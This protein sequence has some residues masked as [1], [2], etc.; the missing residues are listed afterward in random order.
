MPGRVSTPA[1]RRLSDSAPSVRLDI[2]GTQVHS[3]LS[4]IDV[5][6]TVYFGDDSPGFLGD[7]C[8]SRVRRLSSDQQLD[9]RFVDE[10]G[11]EVRL[12]V[13]RG[14]L[15]LTVDGSAASEPVRQVSYNTAT[16]LLEVE[17]EEVGSCVVPVEAR[18][19]MV[20]SLTHI[21]AAAR[22][23]VNF[24]SA[25]APSRASSI[26]SYAAVDETMTSPSVAAPT[27]PPTALARQGPEGGGGAQCEGTPAVLVLDGASPECP[28][29]RPCRRSV[30]F[31]E[32]P[33]PPLEVA[34][35]DEDGDAVR[36]GVL[37]GGGL[38]LTVNGET[39]V[40]EVERIELDRSSGRV[41]VCGA[42]TG[43]CTIPAAMRAQV[44]AR[45]AAVA[46]AAS[47]PLSHTDS[48]SPSSTPVA[49]PS[50]PPSLR[51]RMRSPSATTATTVATAPTAAPKAEFDCHA[52]A[53]GE[54][55]QSPSAD[56][57]PRLRTPD[58][59][60]QLLQPPS[61]LRAL[62]PQSPAAP[63]SAVAGPASSPL[64][65]RNMS[66]TVP[67]T[68]VSSVSDDCLSIGSSRQRLSPVGTDPADRQ[69]QPIS[70]LTVSDS[71]DSV[72]SGPGG[73]RGRQSAPPQHPARS[74]AEACIA[75]AWWADWLVSERRQ[76]ALA[77]ARRGAV[78]GA[79]QSPADA[80]SPPP[81]LRPA[82][83]PGSPPRRYHPPAGGHWQPQQQ[84]QRRGLDNVQPLPVW[85]T[86]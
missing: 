64:V 39:G 14:A 60:S 57:V 21:C 74:A 25:A 86:A 41:T 76:A 12:R 13:S 5:L 15:L 72:P 46:D 55:L 47:V 30:S 33:R 77:G 10:D 79:L 70:P 68:Q 32:S 4:D 24:L 58:S 11:D 23:P 36:L 78:R 52:E 48:G 49:A 54:E 53:A 37:E 61:G 71:A 19:T 43:T 7:T 26:V 9:F 6:Q 38:R 42:V 34:F 59:Q 18:A 35:V 62:E 82:P 50:P 28:E 63:L 81:Q 51:R 2:S 44:A 75:P 3:P 27:P 20:R 65:P 22:V 67:V 56:T 80:G 69:H 85:A 66:Y 83:A 31:A 16:G 45:I 8:A 84:Q 29:R 40:S 1:L 73:A 17:C